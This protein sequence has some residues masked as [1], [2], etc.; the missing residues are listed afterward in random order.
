MR[1]Q[2][3]HVLT[4]GLKVEVLQATVAGIVEKNHD[5]HDFR[6]RKRPVAVIFALG[7]GFYGIFFH[8]TVKKLAEFI[9]HKEN[10]RNFVL[11]E[12]CDYCLYSLCMST[13]KVQQF[14][15]ITGSTEN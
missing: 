10:F 14:S 8:H 13:I 7:R 15:L 12:H 6:L 2:M 1:E 3:A 11:G 4:D 9:C 5:E